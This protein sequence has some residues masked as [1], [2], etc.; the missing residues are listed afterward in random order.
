MSAPKEKATNFL[1][2]GFSGI[3]DSSVFVNGSCG[4]KLQDGGQKDFPLRVFL[5]CLIFQIFSS[6]LLEQL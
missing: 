6:F 3:L 2:D 5:K 4:I 1:I